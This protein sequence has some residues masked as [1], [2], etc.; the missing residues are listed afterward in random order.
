[1]AAVEFLTAS[2]HQVPVRTVLWSGPHQV[3]GFEIKETCESRNWF[4]F[5]T[6]NAPGQHFRGRVRKTSYYQN[7]GLV[8]VVVVGQQGTNNDTN[9][10]LITWFAHTHL[11]SLTFVV[12]D[13]LISQY[14]GA[15]DF[16]CLGQLY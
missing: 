16:C 2:S 4:V 11:Q 13:N 9:T 8:N 6:T 12:V 15:G 3:P 14:N 10:S 1:M 5:A 7:W